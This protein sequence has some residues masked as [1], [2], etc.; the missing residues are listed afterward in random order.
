MGEVNQLDLS[1]LQGY[2]DNIGKDI[3]QQM[4]ELYVQQSKI[5]LVDIE[6]NI[7]VE[8]QNTWQ[9]ACHKMKGA[10]GSVGLLTVHKTLV[11]LETST[12]PAD[13]KAT[14]VKALVTL[15]NDAISV[16]KNWLLDI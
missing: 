9:G 4:L 14:C 6:N 13:V 15:N 8:K 2:L 10:A 5:Y 3:V 16:F 12:A 11:E 1:L 7:L